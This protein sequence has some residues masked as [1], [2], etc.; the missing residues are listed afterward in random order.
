MT[1][2][3][4]PYH[5]DLTGG[6]RPDACDWLV[7]RHGRRIRVAWW[8]GDGRGTVWL[9]PGRTEYIEKY[10]AVAARLVAAGWTVAV[11]D[12]HGQGLSERPRGETRVGHTLGF[13]DY[14]ADLDA[15]LASPRGLDAP[16]PRVLLAHS[17]G[18]TI[19]MRALMTGLDV[20]AAAFSAP[21]WGLDLPKSAKMFAKGLAGLAGPLGLGTRFVPGT[22]P[23]YYVLTQPF[24]GNTLTGDADQ[25]A[26]MAAHLRAHP[27][28]GLGGPSLS[29]LRAALNE[30]EALRRAPLPTLPILVMLGGREVVVSAAAVREVTARLPHAR[31]LDLPRS[32]HEPLME[33]PEIRERALSEILEHFEQYSG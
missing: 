10:A 1:G 3:Q 15:V 13:G 29:W 32:A 6:L 30:T 20:E 28:L 27:E 25:F 31:L 16:Q 5:A 18:G 19:G 23:D 7:P 11:P 9:L 17:M 33:I 24:E 4:A 8:D 14:Q 22:K 12:W 2:L 26:A 21:F